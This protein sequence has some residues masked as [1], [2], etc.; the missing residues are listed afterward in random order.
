MKCKKVDSYRQSKTNGVSTE[1]SE[2]KQQIEY[3]VADRSMRADDDQLTIWRQMR[4][5]DHQT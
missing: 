3:S 5:H 4:N 1:I 2:Q